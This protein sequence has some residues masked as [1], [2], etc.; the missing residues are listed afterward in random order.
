M[1]SIE[2]PNTVS[3]LNAKRDE[4]IRYRDLLEA[5]VRKVTSDIDH[6]EAAISL[7]DPKTTPNEIRAYVVKHRARKGTVKRFILGLLRESHRPMTSSEITALWVS[8]RG[9]RTDT[10]TLIV[11]RKRIGAALIALRR[12]GLAKNDGVFGGLKGWCVA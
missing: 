12:A 2:R 11:I 7:F 8:E 5:E 6:L 9:L 4:L 10:D 3:G 1:S